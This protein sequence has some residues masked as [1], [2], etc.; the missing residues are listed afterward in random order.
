EGKYFRIDAPPN[1]EGW[2]ET[3]LPPL[4]RR[5]LT[6]READVIPGT[7]TILAAANLVG[8]NSTQPAVIRLTPD[9]P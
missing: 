9:A 6:M 8:H 7:H 4:Q 2:Q 3:S 1:T 5:W